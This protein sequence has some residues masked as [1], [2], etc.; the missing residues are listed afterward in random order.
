M[1]AVLSNKLNTL[2]RHMHAVFSN[3]LSIH[4]IHY[5]KERNGERAEHRA[6][7]KGREGR[8]RPDEKVEEEGGVRARSITLS[9]SPSQVFYIL[10]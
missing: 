3:K 8:G 5:S 7:P 9:N 10:Y 1:H 6:P 2:V 4:A